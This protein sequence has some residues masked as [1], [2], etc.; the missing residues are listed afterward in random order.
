MNLPPIDIGELERLPVGRAILKTMLV[1]PVTNYCVTRKRLIRWLEKYPS[2]MALASIEE[3]G[4]WKSMRAAYQNKPGANWLDRVIVNYGSFPMALR[5]RKHVSARL[6]AALIDGCDEDHVHL[7]AVGAG[8]GNNVLEAMA[9]AGHP[10]VRACLIDINAGAFEYGG[11][12]AADLGLSDRV[13]FIQGDACDIRTM[14]DWDPELVSLIGIIEYLSDEELLRLLGAMH[15]A[16]QAG[17]HMLVNSI[18]DRHGVD[19]FLRRVFRLNLNY[20]SP[21]RVS[22]LLAQAGFD[23]CHDQ[24]EPMNVYHLLIGRRA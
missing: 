3:P 9:A 14:V 7:V 1:N 6:L 24:D 5:N 21:A 10:D 19:R 18:S 12:V 11:Q 22:E 4:G 16:M 17:S 15:D 13:Q 2:E 23:A 20:R 8:G